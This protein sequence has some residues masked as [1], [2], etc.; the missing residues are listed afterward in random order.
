MRSSNLGS[1]RPG[2]WEWVSVV[3]AGTRHLVGAGVGI[4]SAGAVSVLLFGGE[5]EAFST[6]GWAAYQA[7]SPTG[8]APLPLASAPAAVAIALAA[9][10]VGVLCGWRRLPVAAPLAAGLPLAGFGLLC[11]LDTYRVAQLFPGSLGPPWMRLVTDQVFLV[12]GGVLLIAAAAAVAR[13]RRPDAKQEGRSARATWLPAVLGVV[14]IPVAWYLV[15]LTNLTVAN[16]AS[17]YWWP[18]RPTASGT[19]T[20]IFVMTIAVIGVLAASRSARLTAVIAGA[21]MLIMGLLGL[22]APTLARAMIDGA[23]FGPAWRHALLLDVTSGLPLLYG[24]V[25][26]VA[27]LMPDVRTRPAASASATPAATATVTT[28]KRNR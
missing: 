22:L 28:A 8:L 24:G 9:G 23:G 26:V 16:Y 7:A 12:L 18:F 14:A 25:L 21:P 17:T 6:Q 2:D 4:A 3:R 5:Y 13:R 15:Q 20:G 27:G 19:M 1:Y 10:I 11:W